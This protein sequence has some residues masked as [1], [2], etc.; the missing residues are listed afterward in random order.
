MD[1]VRDLG[2]GGSFVVLLSATTLYLGL[3]DGF[4]FQ[5]PPGTYNDNTGGF[6]VTGVGVP[7]PAS[8]AVMLVGLAGLGPA[9]GRRVQTKRTD[10]A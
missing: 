1:A 5:G 4:S 8:W 10:A 6:T 2:T 7:E 3:P 9:V